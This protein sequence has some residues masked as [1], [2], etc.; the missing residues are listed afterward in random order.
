MTM[1]TKHT[2]GLWNWTDAYTTGDDAVT[3]T[4]AGRKAAGQT[5][6]GGSRFPAAGTYG[7]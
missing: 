4:P 3:V 1:E 7:A 5:V 2:P 6:G